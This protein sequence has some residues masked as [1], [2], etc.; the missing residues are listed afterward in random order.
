MSHTSSVAPD[1]TAF[2]EGNGTDDQ[3][4][5]LSQILAWSDRELEWSHDYVQ[6]VFPLP[7]RS[8]IQYTAAVIDER[9]FDAFRA[10]KDLRDSLRTAFK[11]ILSF[12]GFELV[13][14]GSGTSTVSIDSRYISLLA[15]FV[16]RTKYT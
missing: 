10:R 5:S 16:L 14:M 1:L 9:V 3:G 2:F 15:L 6:I 13:E 12:Y 11:R 7:E 4:R 8:G